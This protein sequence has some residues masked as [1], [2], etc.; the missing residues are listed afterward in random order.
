MTDNNDSPLPETMEYAGFW[1]LD[2]GFWIL[3]S[4]F[5]ILD[6]ARGYPD[7]YHRPARGDSA[8]DHGDL[9]QCTL[10][11]PT[12]RARP[13]GHYHQLGFSCCCR[14]FILAHQ[15][16]HAGQNDAVHESG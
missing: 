7:R 4:G 12:D 11:G 2:S 15:G 3:D 9:W 8:P 5:W 13:L 1:I 10:A 14:H 6:S 16:G